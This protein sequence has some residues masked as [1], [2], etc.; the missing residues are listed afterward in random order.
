[1]GSLWVRNSV[2]TS[3]TA[4]DFVNFNPSRHI[5]ICAVVMNV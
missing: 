4:K 5:F 1:M 3:Y 2:G